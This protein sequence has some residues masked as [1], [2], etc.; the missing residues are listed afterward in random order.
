MKKS[1][2]MISLVLSM[3][4]TVLYRTPSIS[5]KISEMM[6]A[7]VSRESAWKYLDS[8][9]ITLSMPDELPTTINDPLLMAAWIYIYNQENPFEIWDGSLV[10]GRM[11]AEYVLNNKVPVLWSTPEHCNGNSCTPRLFCAEEPCSEKYPEVTSIY[12]T[13]TLK[14]ISGAEITK[15]VDQMAHE[16]FHHTKQF[17]WVADT[18]YEEYW[19]FYVGAQVSQSTWTDFDSYSSTNIACLKL[20]FVNHNLQVYFRFDPYP[21][22]VISSAILEAPNCPP[23]MDNLI[24]ASTLFANGN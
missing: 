1:I 7:P 18:T 8:Q 23:P 22:K 2:V 17:G 13:P 9:P 12:L 24:T 16:I 19:A 10:S 11:L 20:W 14:K 3:V 6:A 21:Q 15:L 5:G 4:S